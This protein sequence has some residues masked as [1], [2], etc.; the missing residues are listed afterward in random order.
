[1]LFMVGVAT[2]DGAVLFLGDRLA[3]FAARAAYA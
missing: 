3:G 1:M 2:S